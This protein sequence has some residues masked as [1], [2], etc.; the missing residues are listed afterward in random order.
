M[1]LF[2]IAPMFSQKVTN[3]I[4]GVCKKAFVEGRIIV[5]KVIESNL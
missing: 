5:E 1:G 4:K 3:L 2:I